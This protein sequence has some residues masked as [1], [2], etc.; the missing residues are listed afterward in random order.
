MHKEL[1]I[2]T[3]DREYEWI[4]EIDSSVKITV[5]RKGDGPYAAHEIKVPKN[6]GRDVYTFFQHI[7]NRYDSLADFTLFSQ[8]Y[9]FDH[10]ENYVELINGTQ[11]DWEAAA[12]LKDDGL[13]FFDT[14]YQRILVCDRLGNPHHA[15]LELEQA[16]SKIFTEPCPEHFVFAA[17]GHFCISREKIQKKPLGFYERIMHVLEEDPLSPW[18]IERF[19]FYIFT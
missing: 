11:A 18:C 7:V 19:E 8:D 14:C 5:Y 1:V 12:V 9:P 10:V 17:A 4:S 2:A 3:Y 6:V 13:W 16:W 15:G